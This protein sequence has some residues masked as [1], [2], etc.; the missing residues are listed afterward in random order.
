MLGWIVD[1]YIPCARLVIEVDGAVHDQQVEDDARRSDA[2]GA[3]GVQVLR[4][5][6]E[7]VLNDV[8]T[9]VRRIIETIERSTEVAKLSG[10]ARSKG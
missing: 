2:L 4:F 6:N 3:V 5:T 7:E 8:Q 1:F 10:D 9:V